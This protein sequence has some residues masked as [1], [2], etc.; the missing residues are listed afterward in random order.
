MGRSCNEEWLPLILRELENRAPEMRHAAAF[1]AG[2]IAS[3]EAIEPLKIAAIRDPD[4]EV[5]R[6]AVHALGEI[7]GPR[8]K[9]ALKSVLYEGDDDLADAV[10]EA[11]AEIEFNE[12]P[13]RPDF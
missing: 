5:Q 12:D 8:A 1:A 6:A 11:M 7:G 2:E 13:L 9:V 10:Q 4:R 3:E